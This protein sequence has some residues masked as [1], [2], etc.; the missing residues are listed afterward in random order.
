MKRECINID[1]QVTKN[2]K[3]TSQAWTK[4][5]IKTWP[6]LAKT[7]QVILQ[8]EIPKQTLNNIKQARLTI[9]HI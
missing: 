1:D 2:F 3:A 5:M 8:R 9:K 4:G 7:K 6:L